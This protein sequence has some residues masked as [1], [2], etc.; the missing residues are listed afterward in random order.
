MGISRIPGRPGDLACSRQADFWLG[1][2]VH[3]GAS[4]P[5]PHVPF[6]HGPVLHVSLSRRSHAL[7]PAPVAVREGGAVVRL[8]AIPPGS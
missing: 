6:W 7:W 2:F 8:L 5:S 1:R 3:L 4:I